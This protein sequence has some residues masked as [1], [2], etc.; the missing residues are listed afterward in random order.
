MKVRCIW[1]AAERSP[2]VDQRSLL[3]TGVCGSLRLSYSD[4]PAASS[5][6]GWYVVHV[7]NTTGPVSQIINEFLLAYS[8]RAAK[9]KYVLQDRNMVSSKLI[10]HKL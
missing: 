1:C 5:G 9:T 7:I 6:W 4:A 10:N 8:L 3:C 2:A